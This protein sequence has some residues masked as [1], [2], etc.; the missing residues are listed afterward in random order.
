MFI[1]ILDFLCNPFVSRSRQSSMNSFEIKSHRYLETNDS[2]MQ[3]SL[4]AICNYLKFVCML[5]YI[6]DRIKDYSAMCITY[7]HFPVA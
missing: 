6:N 4:C 1:Y 3:S 2:A 7:K 5:R